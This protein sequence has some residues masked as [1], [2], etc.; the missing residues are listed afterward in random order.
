M[1]VI[2]FFRICCFLTVYLLTGI[3]SLTLPVN[4]PGSPG[5]L[6]TLSP[7]ASNPIMT[8]QCTSS[9]IWT[10][11][12][13]YDAQFMA[14]C[15]QAWRI[16]LTGDLL[17]Y[18]STEFEF[19]QKGYS[20]SFLGKPTMTTPRRYVKRESSIYHFS[21]RFTNGVLSRFMY[22]SNCQSWGHPKG[23]SARGTSRTI[24]A[25]GCSEVL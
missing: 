16:Y 1:G 11:S 22:T 24:P 12:T 21:S 18:T 10:G 5:S 13:A 23:N 7:N 2:S 19:L 20:P 6:S 14:A 15:Y 8:E 4:P 3:V 25:V 9:L 17:K